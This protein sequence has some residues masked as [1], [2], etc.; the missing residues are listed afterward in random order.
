MTKPTLKQRMQSAVGEALWELGARFRW[1]WAMR[2]G[3]AMVSASWRGGDHTRN[4]VFDQR[5]YDA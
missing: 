5:D 4:G 1:H 2:T 3:W